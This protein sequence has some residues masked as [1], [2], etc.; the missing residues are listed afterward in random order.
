MYLNIC[1]IDLK[2]F[3]SYEIHF[4]ITEKLKLVSGDVINFFWN[5][6]PYILRMSS[7]TCV[8]WYFTK[9]FSSL[10]YHFFSKVQRSYFG[11]TAF[12]LKHEKA[13]KE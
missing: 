7:R 10:S 6:T 9:H 2:S 12:S 13:N 5:G 4:D 3:V 1:C 8:Y 11:Q